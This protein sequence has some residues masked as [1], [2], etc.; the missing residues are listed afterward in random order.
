MIGLVIVLTV[1]LIIKT[2]H[3]FLAMVLHLAEF[4]EGLDN[5]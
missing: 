4:L 3:V 2:A 5:G 1:L